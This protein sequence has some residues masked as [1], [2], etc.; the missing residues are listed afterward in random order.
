MSPW[1]LLAVAT[2]SAGLGYALGRWRSEVQQEDIL[3]AVARM[4]FLSTQLKQSLTF[5]AEVS[6]S[7]DA[8]KEILAKATEAA[9]TAKDMCALLEE[10]RRARRVSPESI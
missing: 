7:M 5:A 8:D 3:R 10:S 2:V 4:D 9:M 1:A 6:K